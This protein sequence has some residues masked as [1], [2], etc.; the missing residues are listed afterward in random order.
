LEWEQLEV[1]EVAVENLPP[2]PPAAGEWLLTLLIRGRRAEALLGDLEELYRRDCDA[3]GIRRASWL[4]W[5]RALK[6]LGPLLW[7][8]IKKIGIVA[9]VTEMA[10]RY[11]S[12]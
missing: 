3:R 9:A 5:A 2:P 11:L 8:A 6:S 12:G 7:S 10:R 4:Y 1:D